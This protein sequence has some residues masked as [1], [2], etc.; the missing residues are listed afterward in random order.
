MR[1]SDLARTS[2]EIASASGRTEKTALLAG[3]LRTTEP[4]DAPVVITY[5]AGRLPQRRRQTAPSP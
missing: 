4:E 3:L 5:R 2:R 1:L